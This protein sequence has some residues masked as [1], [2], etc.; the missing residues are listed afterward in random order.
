ML[1]QFADRLHHIH[2]HDNNGLV[3]L[4]LPPGTGTIN[5]PAVATA[6]RD[7]GYAKTITLEIFSGIATT[8]C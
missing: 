7:I 2:L 6:L 4:H 3:D 1:R 8:R 5:W